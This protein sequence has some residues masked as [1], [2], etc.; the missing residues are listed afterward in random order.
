MSQQRSLRVQN[1]IEKEENDARH[2]NETNRRM[3]SGILTSAI[4][5]MKS[6]VKSAS[7][8]ERDTR[9]EFVTNVIDDDDDDDTSETMKK[10]KRT[11]TMNAGVNTMNNNNNNNLSYTPPPASA[12]KKDLDQSFIT[13]SLRKSKKK[14]N[15]NEDGTSNNNNVGGGARQLRFAAA[16]NSSRE[17]AD[18]V[19]GTSYNNKDEEVFEDDDDLHTAEEGEDD[20]EAARA[21][22]K[23]K[24]VQMTTTKTTRQITNEQKEGN[25]N[26]GGFVKRGRK[27]FM[28]SIF[29]PMFS[30]LS[31][32]DSAAAALP[33]NAKTSAPPALA[34]N[35]S[36]ETK[37]DAAGTS[38]K[39]ASRL[40]SKKH[41]KLRAT[42]PPK[43][44]VRTSEDD[45]DVDDEEPT[46][47]GSD[48]GVQEILRGSELNAILSGFT[49][50]TDDDEAEFLDSEDE[51]DEEFD[52]WAFIYNL[53]PLDQCVPKR[54][55]AALPVK[56]RGA[57][58][59]TLVLDLDETLVHSNLEEEEGTPDFTFPVRFN[60]ENHAVNVRVRPHLQEFMERVSEKFEVVIFT[61]SQKVYADKLLDHL[62]PEHIYFSHRL[63]RDSCVLVEGNYL[64][65]LSVLGRDLNRTIIIDNSPQAFGFQVA[66]GIPIESW[67]DDS[68]D[69][70][71]LKLLPVLDVLS[72]VSDVKPILNQTFE[73]KKR[74]LRAGAR[75]KR[76]RKS[77][78]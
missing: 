16:A 71:L 51:Y 14:P 58:K 54:R 63:F 5:M 27:R 26:Q 67:Y 52:P 33:L 2:N 20:V 12:T 57:P 21:S 46:T 30:F 75:A 47:S 25:D 35:K 39:S 37:T 43:H 72:Q 40:G 23:Q 60:N 36:T 24:N 53:P 49:V 65:D 19:A 74:T 11:T 4:S 68:K 9:D 38:T 78:V 42:T 15:T 59:N 50:D 1:A 8:R 62:D 17:S 41:A 55:K 56:R 18:D 32:T 28:D 44:D 70:H 48:G 45:N 76:D 73:L 64:K 7:K 10:A 66:N 22:R 61:A 34:N 77:V 31:G 13:S 29:S 69:D 6:I 3:S